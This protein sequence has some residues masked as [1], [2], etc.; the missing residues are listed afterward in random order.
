[1]KTLNSE[2]L[3]QARTEEI[4]NILLHPEHL[5]FFQMGS[6]W[7]FIR[8]MAGYLFTFERIEHGDLQKTLNANV[9]KT[10][11]LNLTGENLFTAIKQRVS[12]F[13]DNDI[14]VTVDRV[15]NKLYLEK[16][17]VEPHIILGFGGEEIPQL[18]M[19]VSW[20]YT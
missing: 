1:M 2:Q 13:P 16:R 6:H 7:L 10:L 9:P 14:V 20:E 5:N 3:L 17:K 19:Y 8:E 18:K 12:L 15:L 11:L 4:F